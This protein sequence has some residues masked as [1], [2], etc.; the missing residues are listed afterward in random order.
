MTGMVE[1]RCAGSNANTHTVSA[2]RASACFQSCGFG[3]VKVLLLG[4]RAHQSAIGIRVK[5]LDSL[6]FCGE[7]PA[8]R[9]DFWHIF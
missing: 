7:Y 1:P 4:S 3:V 9:R 8:Q 6:E 2:K 5:S